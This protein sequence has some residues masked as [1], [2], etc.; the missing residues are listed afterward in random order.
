[1]PVKF[2]DQ[3]YLILLVIFFFYH[4]IIGAMIHC[5]IDLFYDSALFSRTV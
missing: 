5:K 4:M 2:M 3:R 1:M